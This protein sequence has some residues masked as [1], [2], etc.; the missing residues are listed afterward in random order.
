[1]IRRPPRSTVF[2]YTTLFR[3]SESRDQWG[4]A[5][6]VGGILPVDKPVSR[7]Q[8]ARLAQHS[9]ARWDP[10]ARAGAHICGVAFGRS[11]CPDRKRTRRNSSHLVISYTLLRLKK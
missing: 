5:R 11:H 2:P 10:F 3:S 6:P 9:P 4:N 7:L 1:M 8:V